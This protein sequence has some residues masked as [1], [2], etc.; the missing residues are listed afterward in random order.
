MTTYPNK[1]KPIG[2]DKYDGNENRSNGYVATPPPLKSPEAP[3]T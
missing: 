1:F 3:M 2:I